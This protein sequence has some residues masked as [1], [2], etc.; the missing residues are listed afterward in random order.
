MAEPAEHIVTY[1]H[2]TDQK[3]P[4]VLVVETPKGGIPSCLAMPVSTKAAWIDPVNSMTHVRT[5][6]INFLMVFFLITRLVNIYYVIQNLLRACRE[7]EIKFEKALDM[8]ESLSPPYEQKHHANRKYR[9][10]HHDR[11]LGE[12]GRRRK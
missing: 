5:K 9:K 1:E 8:L 7:G 2:F 3:A 11:H 12:N 10:W 4:P 6:N